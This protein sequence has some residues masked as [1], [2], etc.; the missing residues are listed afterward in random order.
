[1]RM[2]KLLTKHFWVLNL[3]TLTLVAY[4]LA[5]G[6]G[7]LAAAALFDVLPAPQ[8]G[9]ARVAP[10]SASKPAAMREQDG[11]DILSRNIF[12]S[13]VGPIVPGSDDYPI[14]DDDLLDLEDGELP[15]IPCPDGRYTLL[16]SVASSSKPEWSFATVSVDRQSRLYRVGDRIGDREVI[17]ISWRYVFLRGASDECYVDMFGETKAP[18]RRAKAPKRLAAKDIKAGIQR[19]GPF[20]RTVDRAVVDAALANPAQFARRVRVRPF[21]KGGEVTGFR[22]RRLQK[23][24]PLAMLGARRGDVIHSVNG[25]NLTSVDQ[26][27][28]AYQN[29]RNDSRLRFEITRRGKPQVLTVNIR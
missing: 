10:V 24:S 25:V 23:N 14:D 9:D 20:E 1:M 7:R 18:A 8:A 17:G 15:M 22:L 29:L 3:L 19:D 16:A 2:E 26:A 28:A 13:A 6:A 11:S 21:K 27:L 12:D 5:G 4:L